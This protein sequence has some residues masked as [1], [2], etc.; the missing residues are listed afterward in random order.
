M[1]KTKEVKEFEYPPKV[2][3][4]GVLKGLWQT[5]KLDVL[6][7]SLMAILLV[8]GLAIDLLG[9]VLGGAL[10]PV[11]QILHGYLGA[12]FTIIY[13]FYIIK[14]FSTRKMRMLMTGINYLDFLLYTVLIVTGVTVASTNQIWVDNLPW[15]ADALSSLR[16]YAPSIHTITT[17]VWLLI[18]T[19]LP[20]GFL[21][22]I[23][24]I[25]LASI[26]G[27]ND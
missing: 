9:F 19:L 23:A 17:Y 14:I 12:I 25:Y 10:A 2:T 8:T 13:P 7:H 5:S 18:S 3:F 20:G 16:Q 21:H 24:T 6:F 27:E 26:K 4:G 22:G 11:R 15:L 1:S